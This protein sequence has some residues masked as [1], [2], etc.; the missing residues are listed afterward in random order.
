MGGERVL[1]VDN[2]ADIRRFIEVNLRVE[3]FEA[4]RR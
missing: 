4:L 3:G 2:E 1:V